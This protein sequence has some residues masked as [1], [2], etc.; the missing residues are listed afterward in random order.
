VRAEVEAIN[1]ARHA[2]YLQDASDTGRPLVEIEAVAGARLREK[3]LPGD[4]IHNAA[5]TW[6][7]KQ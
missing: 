2:A 4:W 6:V 1:A 5:G 3:A 7:Q